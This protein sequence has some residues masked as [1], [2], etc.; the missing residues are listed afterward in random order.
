M[1]VVKINYTRNRRAIKAHLRYITHRRGLDKQT[2]TRTLF[3][4]EGTLT[5]QA[6]YE[7]IDEAKR[8]TVF[9]KVIL[10]PDPRREDTGR[11]LNLWQLTRQTAATLSTALNKKI[12]FLAVEHNDHAPHRH[13][14]AVFFIPG[15]LSRQE[16]RLLAQTARLSATEDAHLQRRARDMLLHN[17]RRLKLRSLSLNTPRQGGGGSSPRLQGGCPNCG[18]GQ[19]SGVPVFYSYCPSCHVR[20]RGNRGV[21]LSREVR[22]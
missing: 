19:S 22:Q 21:S 9:Y 18:Y 7:L 6:A 5:K 20:L 14:H 12:R 11:D 16:F 2:T 3:T 13:V 17:P 8:G 10:S 15:R 1:A 4:Q